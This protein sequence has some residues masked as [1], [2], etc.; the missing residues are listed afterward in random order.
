MTKISQQHAV[1]HVCGLARTTSD[2]FVL[3]GGDCCHFTGVFRPTPF[4]PLPSH[5]ASSSASKSLHPGYYSQTVSTMSPPTKEDDA[6]VGSDADKGNTAPLT[7]LASPICRLAM[8]EHSFYEFAQLAQQSV[9]K[10]Q[11]LDAHPNIMICLAHDN[12]LFQELPLYNA[13]TSKDI[14]DWFELGI[15]ERLRWRFLS[16]LA[17]RDQPERKPR[18]NGVYRD[19][20]LLRW[21]KEQGFEFATQEV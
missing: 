18:L 6:D 14:N 21:N 9:E 17:K 19:G 8:H 12:A 16:E 3:L 1:G 5:I 10:L 15:K 4:V 11:P 2:T 20:K 7:G 13:D